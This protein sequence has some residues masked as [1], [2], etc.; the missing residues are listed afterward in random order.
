MNN[1]RMLSVDLDKELVKNYGL[2]RIVWGCDVFV[3]GIP[4]IKTF[5]AVNIVITILLWTI[6][7][8]PI[9]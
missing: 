7:N 2:W 5:T 9:W 3:S 6:L 4:I 1:W 8:S